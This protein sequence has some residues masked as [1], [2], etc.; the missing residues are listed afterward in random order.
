MSN[1]G[2]EYT[3]AAIFSFSMSKCRS[4]GYSEIIGNIM[5]WKSHTHLFPLFYDATYR[6]IAL[7]SMCFLRKFLCVHVYVAFDVEQRN[8]TRRPFIGLSMIHLSYLF[9][10]SSR[11]FCHNVSTLI[12]SYLINLRFLYET[13]FA[14]T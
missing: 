2:N 4:W 12:T 8:T 1:H 9:F 3:I 10:L 13:Y 6:T 11:S 5:N 7:L 14:S